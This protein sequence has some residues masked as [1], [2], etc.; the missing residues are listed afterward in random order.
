M[1]KK[2]PVSPVLLTL[3]LLL[4]VMVIYAVSYF[5]PAQSELTLMRA[6][7]AVAEAEAKIYESYL[8]DP[9]HLQKEIDALEDELA[10]MSNDYTN[11]SNVN[12]EISQAIQMYDV[13][14]ASVSLSTVETYNGHR[15]LP[16]NLTIK[17]TTENI[18][19]FI[20]HFE[21][22]M[23]GSYVV[24]GVAMETTAARTEADIVLYLCTPAV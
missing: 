15:A 18:L 7:V 20:Q 4:V 19:Q 24:R 6:D 22:N 1:K 11:D 10:K 12:F 14:L 16:I 17:G 9:S 23:I 21:T 8:N 3:L 5:I 2:M 13:S